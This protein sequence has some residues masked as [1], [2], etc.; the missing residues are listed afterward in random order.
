[1]TEK[2]RIVVGMSGGV[3]SSVT[4][5]LLQA[6]GHE[7]I[8]LFM[9]NWDSLLNNDLQGN[10]NQD[11]CPQEQDY[12]DALAVCQ[13]LNI[14]LERIDF[15]KEYWDNVFTY[16]LEEFKKSRTPNPD[17]L[18]NKYIKFD[19]F[20]KYAQK[21]L[22]ADDIAMG[23]YARINYNPITKQYQLLKG[24]DDNKDQSYFLCQLTQ[25]QL[26]Y[27]LFPLG[28]KTKT[29]VRELAKIYNLPTATKK[30]STGICFIG[31][32]NFQTFLTNYL[33][34]NPGKIV[35]INTKTTIGNHNGVYYYTLGQ[36]KGIN[37]SG[38]K[39]PYFVVEKDVTNNILYVANDNEN[40]WLMNS[41]CTVKSL[42]WIN[43]STLKKSLKCNAKFR[44]RQSDVAVIIN[45]INNDEIKVEFSEKIRA[46]TP[47][48]TAVF[49]DGDICLGGGVIDQ[50]FR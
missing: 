50:I 15:V 47:G 35:D 49:Y 26:K 9:R 45:F 2:K 19:A 8:G 46:I 22:Q 16:F 20:L 14:K 32:R 25:K 37:L 43:N 17:I 40:K 38:M 6:E 12:L 11:I 30:D 1:M 18:C 28:N 33:P 5:A 7:V 4:A 10:N 39:V 42:N 13:K 48:Q 23:H 31:N 3:D 27:S 29:E 21:N 44:Y 34:A 24:I 41:G 36:R